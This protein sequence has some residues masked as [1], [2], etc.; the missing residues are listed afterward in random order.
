MTVK[1]IMTGRRRTGQTLADHR[2][3]MREVH[4][5]IVLDYI[6]TDPARAPRRYV[7]NHVLHAPAATPRDF[8]TELWFPDVADIAA[9]RQ[10]DFYRNHL[11]PDEPNMVDTATVTAMVT[12]EVPPSTGAG[13]GFKVIF[14]HR[15][16]PNLGR[17][18]FEAGWSAMTADWPRSR[19]HILSPAPFD[20]IDS[21]RL[22]SHAAAA[23]F[24]T[25]AGQ[26]WLDRLLD[27]GLIGDSDVLIAQEFVLFDGA[28][29]APKEG[30]LP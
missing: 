25:G 17:D 2:L 20:G 3:H 9:S 22:P 1:L 11:L 26:V 4:G 18:A 15:A 24:V 8:L 29:T 27:A 23:Q 16:A 28:K 10:T 5:Q 21:V 19:S 12:R 6:R 30:S 13:Q 14:L 7:Q